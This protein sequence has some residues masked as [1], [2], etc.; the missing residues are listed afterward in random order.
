MIKELQISPFARPLLV[1]IIG[2]LLQENFFVAYESLFLLL[3]LWGFL[4]FSWILSNRS[5]L[6]YDG[7]WVWGVTFILILLGASILRTFYVESG[8][9]FSFVNEEFLLLTECLQSDLL[10]KIETL[11]LT[12][13]EKAILATITL[14]YR[15][16]G[17]AGE[18]YPQSIKHGC[19]GG[20][21]TR[22]LK[23][24]EFRIS[25]REISRF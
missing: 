15:E 9:C 1:W 7:R 8:Y 11:N 20:A 17:S 16:F 14:G 19:R 6:V 18:I 22:P 21:S 2:I 24:A 25:R 10:K 5:V 3:V 4:L 13:E 12:E 23:F